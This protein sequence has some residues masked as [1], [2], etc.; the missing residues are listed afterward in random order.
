MMTATRKL[1]SKEITQAIA[2]YARKHGMYASTVR[3]VSVH[4]YAAIAAYMANHS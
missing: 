3:T 1:T 2:A 4:F